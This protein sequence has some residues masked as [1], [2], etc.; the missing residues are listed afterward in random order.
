MA[1]REVVPVAGARDALVVLGQQ[2][3]L[4]RHACT[5]TA[6]EL[7]Q[8]AGISERTVLAIEAGAAGSSIGNVFNLAVLTGVSLFGAESKAE[9]A[10]MRRRGEERLALMPSRVYSPRDDEPDAA[11]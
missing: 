9:L 5:W 3:R 8:R 4:A 6:S 11:F 7:A 1:R 2:I 10:V